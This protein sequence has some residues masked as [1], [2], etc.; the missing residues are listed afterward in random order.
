MSITVRMG[1]VKLGILTSFS[2]APHADSQAAAYNLVMRSA[3][4]FTPGR[5]VYE[6]S[7]ARVIGC[8]EQSEQ[9]DGRYRPPTPRRRR[10]RKSR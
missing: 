5:A 3:T 2:A 4:D 10:K 8:S 7:L 9:K 6:V 1:D